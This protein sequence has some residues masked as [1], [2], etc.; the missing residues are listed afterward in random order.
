M[1]QHEV[2]H[3]GQSDAASASL[4]GPPFIHSVKTFEYSFQVFPRNPYTGISYPENHAAVAAIQ[5][6]FNLAAF[7][8]LQRVIH[9]IVKN[10]ADV[11]FHRNEVIGSIEIVSLEAETKIFCVKSR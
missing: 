10:S 7:G 11:C 2:F 6:D 9:Q 1:K 4:P 5:G 8:V 3:N